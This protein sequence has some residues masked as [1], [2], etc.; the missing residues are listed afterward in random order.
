ML[1]AWLGQARTVA[2]ANGMIVRNRILVQPPNV[3]RKRRA[4]Q[5]DS[6][7]V[8][9]SASAS[10]SCW[11][12]CSLRYCGSSFLM[13]CHHDRRP[14][15]QVSGGKGGWCTELHRDPAEGESTIGIVV[16]F[17]AL[18][19]QLDGHVSIWHL[20]G[21]QVQALMVLRRISRSC[22]ELSLSEKRRRF[23]LTSPPSIMSRGPLKNP[24]VRTARP[25]PAKA[26]CL[27][28]RSIAN[29]WLTLNGP[30]LS[31]GALKK[32]GSSP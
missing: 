24:A 9:T 5:V 8:A 4:N 19:E 2:A 28:R 14:L 17:P 13:C 25:R 3:E 7:A 20:V 12:A 23:P 27:M 31:C 22:P 10:R 18:D 11:A 29:S 30:R 16:G 21:R 1:G 32:N 6:H 26:S 15:K